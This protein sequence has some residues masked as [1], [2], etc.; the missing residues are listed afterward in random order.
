M[1]VASLLLDTDDPHTLG[2]EIWFVSDAICCDRPS[3][4][5]QLLHLFDLIHLH[6]SPSILCRL[7]KQ[8][9][10]QKYMARS[11]LFQIRQARSQQRPQAGWLS[12]LEK[13]R[14]RR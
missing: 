10:L 4:I 12:C 3:T 14:L 6:V 2:K 1:A 8:Q 9:G 7:M 13:D 11:K 5:I